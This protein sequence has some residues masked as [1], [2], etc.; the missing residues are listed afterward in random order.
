MPCGRLEG[1]QLGQGR[2]P[3]HVRSAKMNSAQHRLRS[4]ILPDR[5]SATKLRQVSLEPEMSS[6]AEE[7]LASRLRGPL[8]SPGS[9][10]FDE[11]RR[12]WNAMIDRRPALI[13]QCLGAADVIASVVYARERGL[14]LSVRGGGH[15]VS[16]SAVVDG[17]LM[18]DL[19]RMQAVRV[20]PCRKM[21]QVGPGATWAHVDAETQAFGLA[22]TGGVVAT[23]G[24]GGL[25]L[26]GG[27]GWLQG[28]YGLACDNLMAADV[29]TAD[30]RLVKASDAENPDL[31]WGLRGGGGNFGVVTS[32]EFRVHDVGE[33]YGGLV[34]HPLDAAR[35]AF[36]FWEEFMR[37][38]PDELTTQFGLVT[39]PDGNKICA[40]FVCYS[41][42]ANEAEQVLRPLREF[43]PP[44]LDGLRP[45]RYA[46]VQNIFTPGFPAGR[47]SYWKSHFVERLKA[48]A[49]EILA[50]GYAASPAPSGGIV[51]EHLSGQ[52]A[53]VEP[54]ATAF[55][56]RRSRFNLL[57]AAIWDDSKQDEMRKAWAR[58]LW[59]A[60][61]RYSSGSTYVNYLDA[62]DGAA[63]RV[64]RAY[65][66]ETYA[67]LLALKRKYDPQNVFRMNQNIAP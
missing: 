41:G 17:G 27:L 11:A 3:S 21:V 66:P 31:F 46:D 34:A 57:I 40:V 15:N 64:R 47:R 22:T 67:K 8:L 6:H 39:V 43:G 18:I 4:S 5:R 32:F 35:E 52:A 16:G 58:N 65:S 55:A 62:D 48:D 25:T 38:A 26:G 61:G 9:P 36:A 19:S 60:T 63:D 49:I 29:V 30:G 7:I 23:T 51:I 28:K 54:D 20:A 1:A 45:M 14:M 59:E 50:Q 56:L 42:P 10:G 44:L 24:V 13:S 33:L 37:D 53:R 2:K 12:V